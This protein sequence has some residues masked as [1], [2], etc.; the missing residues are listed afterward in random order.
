MADL[1]TPSLTAAFVELRSSATSANAASAV[2]SARSIGEFISRPY[3]ILP[4]S[5]IFHGP[6]F[7]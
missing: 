1:L 5:L 2:S 3:P 7:H 6:E 4:S